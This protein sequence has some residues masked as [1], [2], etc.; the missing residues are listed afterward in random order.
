MKSIEDT[1]LK[2]TS[3]RRYER[4][5]IA[6]EKLDFIY[7]AIENTPTSYNGQQFSVIAIDDQKIKE[8]LYVITNQKQIKTC[9]VFLAFCMD[10]NKIKTLAKAKDLEFPPFQ[11]TMDGVIVGIVDA[12][13]AMQNAVVAAQSME[14][15]SCCVGYLRTADPAAISQILKLPEGVFAVC[16]L[17]LGVPREQPD[18]KPKQNR[19]LVIHKNHYRTDDMTP[20]LFDYDETISLYN[21]HRN[22]S[23][24]ENDWCGHILDYYRI[25]MNYDME[26][27]LKKQ[28][29]NLF[30]EK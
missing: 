13:L 30:P 22:G 9:N 12:A 28:G 20:E 25:A 26:G 21:R 3:V 23:T 29:F 14:L 24:S 17:T 7:R 16:G 15:G 8:E 1:L 2:R 27:A 18:L 4:E 6:P 11:N 5:D 10:F 19:S